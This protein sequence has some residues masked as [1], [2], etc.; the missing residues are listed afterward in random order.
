MN[1]W[2]LTGQTASQYFAAIQFRLIM[3]S[4]VI[5]EV[6]P[7][8]SEKLQVELISKSEAVAAKRYTAGINSMFWHLSKE[9]AKKLSLAQINSLPEDEKLVVRT[10]LTFVK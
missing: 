5:S 8:L 6:R 3:A 10:A 4:L 1:P 9:A 7:K 2:Y